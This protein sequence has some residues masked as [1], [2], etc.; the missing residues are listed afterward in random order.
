MLSTSEQKNEDKLTDDELI[1]NFLTFF[2]AGMDTTG[3]LIT[4]LMYF[5]SEN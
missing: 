5:L 3:H 1:S 4:T 2:L